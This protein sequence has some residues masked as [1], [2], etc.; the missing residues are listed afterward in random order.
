MIDTCSDCQ[1]TKFLPREGANRNTGASDRAKIDPYFSRVYCLACILG[2]TMRIPSTPVFITALCFGLSIGPTRTGAWESDVHYG[3]TLWLA[4]KAGYS[5]SDAKT[6]ADA[7]QGVDDSWLTGPLQSTA[8][9][10]CL[11]TPDSVGAVTVHGH[12]FA[13]ERDPPDSPANRHV[14]P[15]KIWKQVRERPIPQPSAATPS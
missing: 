3:L 9:A 2:M 10:A 8:I 13:S 6:I 4:V 5:S 7:N 1:D 15:G 12:H 14:T 11:T